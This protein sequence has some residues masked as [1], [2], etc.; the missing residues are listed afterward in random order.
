MDK[1]PDKKNEVN[2]FENGFL[3][4][5]NA[6]AHNLAISRANNRGDNYGNQT[7]P[8][9]V[10]FPHITTAI[11]SATDST[12]ITRLTQGQAGAVANSIATSLTRMNSLINAGLIPFFV[13]KLSKGEYYSPRLLTLIRRRIK[14]MAERKGGSKKRGAAGKASKR[15]GASKKR[16]AAAK[17]GAKRAAARAVK[18]AAVVADPALDNLN[19]IEHVVVLVMENRSFDHMLGYLKLEGVN[20]DV[21]GLDAN[22][23][24]KLGTKTFRV[25]LLTETV[26][27]RGQDPC[28]EG[29]CVDDQ[30]NGP[31]GPN[32]GFVSSYAAHHKGDPADG[33]V[34]GFYN[35]SSLPVYDHLAR[36]FCICDRWFCSVRGATW[37][38]RLYAVAGRADGSRDNKTPPIYNLPSFVR[39]LDAKNVPWRWYSHDF[40]TLRLA[41]ARFRVGRS[42]NFAFFD[43]RIDFGDTSFLEDAS[44][45]NLAAVSWIDPFFGHVNP[46]RQ[47]DDHP[48]RADLM[49]GQELVLRLYNAVVTG[50]KW[51]KTLLV[52]VY[53]EHGGFFDHV[54]PPPAEDD[55]PMFRQY[56]VR[57]PAF[58]V[59][60]FVE[61]GKVSHMTFDH[62]SIIKTILLR[63]CR[64]A[65]GSIPDM[66]ARVM[67]ANH[68]GHLLTL[69]DA[70][71][72]TPVSS[73]RHLIDRVAQW[74]AATFRDSMMELASSEPEPPP[75]P[76]EV[77]EGMRAARIFLRQRGLPEGQP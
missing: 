37:P 4:Q 53:D 75:P 55:N 58:V 57:V 22:M 26:L 66:G 60:P 72:A 68:L 13:C 73:F 51:N 43:R 2:T 6:A 35:G 3:A 16:G 18:F 32:T 39:H 48:S 7:L 25:R 71:A 40:A 67:S 44:S 50:P 17:A 56:G 46:F 65:D 20:P 12:T 1:W 45:G 76:N 33:L 24:N 64:R 69:G 15:S 70:R 77:Q 28:H 42:K 74:R 8:G 5:L 54:A 23:S 14:T 31:D 21:D 63:F 47:N 11:G 59:S 41:D 34:M 62:T 10:N 29:K 61:R 9:Q 36:N 52:I 30:L 19:K 27:K 38:N 49:A